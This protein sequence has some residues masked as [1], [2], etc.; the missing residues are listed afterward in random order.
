[1]LSTIAAVTTT[2]PDTFLSTDMKD[3]ITSF[4][5]SALKTA[6]DYQ[7][8]IIPLGLGIWGA[9]KPVKAGVGYLKRQVFSKR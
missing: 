1:M 2:L 6:T 3:F 4:G 9:V 5:G 7:F 8:L